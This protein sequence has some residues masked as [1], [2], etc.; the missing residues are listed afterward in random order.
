MDTQRIDV[1][2]R[3]SVDSG[4]QCGGSST[5]GLRGTRIVNSNGEPHNNRYRPAGLFLRQI[6]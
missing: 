6:L 5:P 4:G 2:Q 1:H 3:T